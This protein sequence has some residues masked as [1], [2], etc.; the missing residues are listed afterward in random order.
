MKVFVS[1]VI[2]GLEVFRDAA[3]S[4]IATLG[5][6]AI[7]AEDFSAS[8]QGPRRECLSAVR[9]SDAMVLLLGET[10]G[11]QQ[12]SGLSATHEEY[13]EARNNTPVLAFV[14][15]GISPEPHQREFIKEVRS[16]ESGLFTATFTGSEDLRS[17]VT[18]A[19]HDLIIN[20]KTTPVDT[21]DTADRARA[22][23][24]TERTTSNTGLLIAVAH[25]PTRQSCDPQN[26][27][28]TAFATTCWRRP[29]PVST[30]SS[31]PQTAQGSQSRIPGSRFR[32]AP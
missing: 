15:G 7:R 10:Y 11:Q 26:S 13:R 14:Q 24:P 21:N 6:E 1:S 27:I 25:G 28:T 3:V 2:T 12:Q 30:P 22:L 20:M 32:R 8:S 16:W 17:R 18:K 23:I 5:Y 31:N 29:S 9:S 4:A 19:L